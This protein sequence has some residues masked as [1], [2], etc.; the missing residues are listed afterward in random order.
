MSLVEFNDDLLALGP[1]NNRRSD[2]GGAEIEPCNSLTPNILVVDDDPLVRC[3]LSHLY[4]ESG[5]IVEA[6]GCAEDALAQLAQGRTDFV[7]TDIKLPGIGGAEL[8]ANMQ[9][10]HP[11]VPVI[12]ITGYL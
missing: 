6:V 9:E 11:D 3:Q 2:A 7:I 10:S 12:A 5:Y 8:I 4:E 1:T